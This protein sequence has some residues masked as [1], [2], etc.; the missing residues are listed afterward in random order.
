LAQ[1][2]SLGSEQLLNIYFCKSKLA[3][4]IESLF[5]RGKFPCTFTHFTYKAKREKKK[6]R[7]ATQKGK[8]SGILVTY[9]TAAR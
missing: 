6:N 1:I 8:T 4:V 5:T 7:E 3:L 2:N 9:R